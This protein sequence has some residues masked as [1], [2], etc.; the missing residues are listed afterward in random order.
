MCV[1][2]HPILTQTKS[3]QIPCTYVLEV[4]QH[5][6]L[7]LDIAAF[8]MVY[9]VIHVINQIMNGWR[10]TESVVYFIQYATVIFNYI[11]YQSFK[12]W[13][14]FFYFTVICIPIK[15]HINEIRHVQQHYETLSVVNVLFCCCWLSMI[16][17]LCICILYVV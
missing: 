11:K 14:I 17:N 9:L 6:W 1:L 8:L 13:C 2:V 4:M 10:L 15:N 7:L 5:I 3:N 16:Y 12:Y